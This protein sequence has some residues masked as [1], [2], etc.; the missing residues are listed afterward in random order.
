LPETPIRH[1]GHTV[2]RPIKQHAI[3]M[4]EFIVATDPITRAPRDAAGWAALLDVNALPVLA[5]TAALIE[6]MR[7]NEELADAHL[8]A[9]TISLDPLMTVKLLSHV[10]R[11]RSGR[12]GGEPETVTAALVMLG[13]TP[14]FD[15][16]PAQATVEDV[17]ALHP[18]A[19]DGFN[20]VLRRAHRAANFAIGFAVQ[21]L[22]HDAAVIHGAALL[23]EMVELMLW[24][25]APAFAIE[26]GRRQAADATLRSAEVQRQL[27]HTTLP[28]LHHLLMVRW[29]LPSLLIRITDGQMHND[30]AQVRNV[31]L[32]IRVAR[33]TA[34]GW[35][36]P[37]LPD[38]VRD[39][40]ELL[41]LGHEPTL[42]L[43]RAIDA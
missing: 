28:E 22:D 4:L 21:R 6:D 20:S 32:A 39:I 5:E 31:L 38:D 43:L 10:G 2:R 29:R 37:A 40:A 41:H 33:H 3:A 11:L 36:N 26:M 30:S 12:E 27:L 14:F 9:Q 13:I 8:L 35:D 25:R 7:A 15:A 1:E 18:E 17:L 24:L 19:L 42:Q 16:F 23:H 34:A